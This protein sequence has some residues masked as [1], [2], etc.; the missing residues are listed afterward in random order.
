MHKTKML[1][2]QRKQTDV[3]VEGEFMSEQNM[4]DAGYSE[5]FGSVFMTVSVFS[6]L[7]STVKT[8]SINRLNT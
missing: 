8:S 4:K 6:S 5:S 3:S 7:L 1:V 2:I